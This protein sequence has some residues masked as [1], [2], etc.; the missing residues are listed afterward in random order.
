MQMPIPV[1]IGQ[2]GGRWIPRKT[3][4]T[5]TSDVTD[6]FRFI[7]NNGGTITA[8]GLNVA[9]TERGQHIYNSVNPQWRSTILD[10]TVST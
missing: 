9:Q 8:V 2:Y 6:A 1:N 3:L 4:H 7:N 5:N 10:I